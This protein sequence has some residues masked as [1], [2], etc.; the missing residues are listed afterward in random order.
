MYLAGGAHPN[1]GLTRR[2]L[3]QA[4]ATAE[5]LVTDAEVLQE[6]L[7]RYVAIDRR[8]LIDEAMGTILGLVDQVFPIER[9]DVGAARDIVVSTRLSARDAIH[10]AVMRRRGVDQIMSFDRGF[11]DVPGIV[12]ISG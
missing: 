1:Q 7:H 10:V 8:H 4:V 11:D 6:I 5:V 9:A 3:E 2:L 12:R